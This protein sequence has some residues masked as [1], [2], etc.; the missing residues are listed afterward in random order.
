VSAP[1]KPMTKAES[2]RQAKEVLRW[3]HFRPSAAAAYARCRRR[4]EV[5]VEF[6]PWAK[7][8]EIQDRLRDALATHIREDCKQ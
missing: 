8:G 7:D 5:R 6:V 4:H 1:A 3:G 2:L